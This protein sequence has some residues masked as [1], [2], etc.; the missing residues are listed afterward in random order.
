MISKRERR[1]MAIGGALIVGMVTFSRIVPMWRAWQRGAHTSAL[2]MTAAVA[3][4]EAAVRTL[5]EKLDSLEARKGRF[6]QLA[7]LLLD[8]ESPATAAEAL[9]VLVSGA[10][11]RAGVRVVKLHASVDTTND[12]LLRRVWVSAELEGDIRGVANMISTLEHGPALLAIRELTI[13][14]PDPAGS[15][16]QPERLG[17]WL[18]IAGLAV[19]G[20]LARGGTS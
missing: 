4:T 19:D 2:E 10:A 20:S 7:P 18:R 16:D 14:Q 9:R 6:L 8:A 5:E 3:R 17:V 11:E 1:V 13:T 12:T 15:S